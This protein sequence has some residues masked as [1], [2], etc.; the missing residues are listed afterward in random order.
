MKFTHLDLFSGLGGFS[1]AARWAGFETIGFSEIDPYCCKVLAKNFPGI[2]NYG[3][4][5][6]L[7]GEIIWK[8]LARNVENEKE[9][10]TDP[11]ANRAT[12]HEPGHGELRIENE[13]GKMTGNGVSAERTKSS[14]IMAGSVCAA[15]KQQENFYQSTIRTEMEITKDE[16]I[17]LKLGNSRLGEDCPTI[18]KSSVSTA[19]TRKHYTENVHTRIDLLT[20]GVPCQPASLAGKRKGA[21]DDRWLWPETLR[22]IR[23]INP[24]WCLLENVPGLLALDGGMEFERLCL[25]LEDAGYEVQPLVIPACAV[26]APHRRDRVWIVAHSASNLRRA[27]R[28]DG[29]ESF[30]GGGQALADTLEPGLTELQ[31]QC[32]PA[33]P[34]RRPKL[35]TKTWRLTQPAVR[36]RTD[37]LSLEL[38]LIRRVN[39]EFSNNSE[40][41]AKAEIITGR[42]LRYVWEHKEIATT[43]PDIYRSRLLSCVPEMSYADSCH[44]WILGHWIKEDEGL[45]DLWAAFSA[46]PQQEAQKLQCELLERIRKKKRAQAVASD[47]DRL[48]ALGNAIVPQV[49][50]QILRAIK[51]ADI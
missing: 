49:A 50:Y 28:H 1:L 43:S 27:S 42:I 15:E 23:E 29:S 22:L 48:K 12:Q 30:D 20:A 44:R 11:I 4:I 26:N 14:P 35:T 13:T 45:R 6:K 40:A 21:E 16:P 33:E 3:D 36:R 2:P 38:D 46:K 51:E 9:R 47:R 41:I 32:S 8:D 25:A 17:S 34:S 31:G 24:T 5:T 37:G 18:I 39:N 10:R 19:I 7:T